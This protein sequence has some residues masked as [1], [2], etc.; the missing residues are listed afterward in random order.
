[1]SVEPWITEAVFDRGVLSP[2][3]L[4]FE[5]PI[6]HYIADGHI[7]RIRPVVG[8]TVAP[9]KW[10]YPYEFTMRAGHKRFYLADKPLTEVA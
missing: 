1:M 7:A 6:S 8:M 9:G 4:R 3:I 2:S 5:W 10:A